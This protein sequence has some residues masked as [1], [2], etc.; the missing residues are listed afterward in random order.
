[1]QDAEA[2]RS[3]LR[4][5]RESAAKQQ[6]A[7]PGA[8]TPSTA[9]S[10]LPS[11]DFSPPLIR[12]HP[13][14]RHPGKADLGE[15][16]L[17]D[18]QQEQPPQA[19][20]ISHRPHVPDL[21]YSPAPRV[22][23]AAVYDSQGA[24][25]GAGQ[26]VG[27]GAGQG[28]GQGGEQGGEQG[29]EGSGEGRP[30]SVDRQSVRQAVAREGAVQEEV[31]DNLSMVQPL[32]AAAHSA[33][34]RGAAVREDS[35]GAVTTNVE[36]RHAH[37]GRGGGGAG[38][39]GRTQVGR[40][41]TGGLLV[42]TAPQWPVGRRASE[43]E[44]RARLQGRINSLLCS[45]GPDRQEHT[46]RQI[47]EVVYQLAIQDPTAK[48]LSV[49]TVSLGG[50]SLA[51]YLHLA[52]QCYPDL[53]QCVT[54][55]DL[56]NL[57]P[58][59]TQAVRQL[60]RLPSLTALHFHETPIRS[61][62]LPLFQCMSRLRRL[63]IACANPSDVLNLSA[64][65]QAKSPTPSDPISKPQ[66]FQSL[67]ELHVSRVTDSI[68]QQVGVLTSLELLSCTYSKEVTCRG[69]IH[70]RGMLNLKRLQLVPTILIK[71]FGSNDH[72]SDYYRMCTRLGL[73]LS[74]PEYRLP[75]IIQTFQRPP[76][77]GAAASAS[78]DPSNRIDGSIW[79]VVGALPGLQHLEL[80]APEPST[81]ALRSLSTIT[82][83][84]T[85]HITGTALDDSDL[86]CLFG[87][88]MLTD[89]SLA[90]WTFAADHAVRTVIQGMTHLKSLDLSGTAISQGAAVHLQ[91]LERLGR[92]KLQQCIGMSKLFVEH[93]SQ[94]PAL[95]E[96]DL[97]CNNMQ[98][99]WLLPVLEGKKVTRLGVR[100]CGFVARTLKG[101]QRDWIEI[102]LRSN[103]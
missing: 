67:R 15:V 48:E 6:A 81:T 54:S 58:V 49:S 27:Q 8:P 92:L 17:L 65:R 94:V 74:F 44:V 10:A 98:H 19:R 1:M 26:G 70:L 40:G 21:P 60:L 34:S 25:Q 101:L 62:A 99:A 82:H 2:R 87:F 47:N 76:K 89:V 29:A 3:R 16:D 11:P 50:P 63:V 52:P 93:L 73:K 46:T 53:L 96:L 68:L 55:L 64:R 79:E 61:D 7:S 69:W 24:G 12:T 35:G 22:S 43:A 33:G 13:R 37:R 18:G 39:A 103:E 75:K 56:R 88:S 90:A 71:K 91:A 31:F 32:I 45:V 97:G 85:L 28:T 80:H 4:S 86:L 77:K 42:G 72:H 38:R 30:A 14:V 84:T 66:P 20:G 57:Q 83:L 9:I 23:S 95:R 78:E 5:M 102:D 36:E 41:D 51:Y 59:S 100:G